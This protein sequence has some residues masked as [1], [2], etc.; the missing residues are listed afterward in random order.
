MAGRESPPAVVSWISGGAKGRKHTRGNNNTRQPYLI[1]VRLVAHSH[2]T[3]TS[4]P[5][6]L[7][8]LL[9][10]A[11]GPR[12][13][14]RTM[15]RD[16]ND[17]NISI[18]I[19]NSDGT[20]QPSSTSPAASSA[21]HGHAPAKKK[22]K[23]NK[24]TLSCEECV[25]RKTKVSNQQPRPSLRRNS[26]PPPTAQTPHPPPPPPHSHISTSIHYLIHQS[27]ARRLMVSAVRPHQT[28][29]LGL[30]QTPVALPLLKHRQP[31]C[32]FCRQVCMCPS[33]CPPHAC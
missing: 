6:S 10:P 19:T 11:L 8:Q 30:H 28:P 7:C 14:C 18:S 33:T 9:E 15:K 12:R 27:H 17:G 16:D 5:A 2:T 32:F 24:P 29:L 22:Q 1:P 13:P 26:P 3:P 23:R 31:D 4:T 21:T 25:E 20:S